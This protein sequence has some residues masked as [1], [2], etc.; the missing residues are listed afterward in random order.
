MLKKINF[1]FLVQLKAI[2][3]L[4]QR[5]PHVQDVL[6][7]DPLGGLSHPVL[8]E[9]SNILVLLISAPLRCRGYSICAGYCC[10]II[11]SYKP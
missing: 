2:E 1:V 10:G 8:Q 3:F 9:A 7:K 6:C 11:G 5:T 4:L